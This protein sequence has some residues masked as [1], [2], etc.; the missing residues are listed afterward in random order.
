MCHVE[1]LIG[2][3]GGLCES[4]GADRTDIDRLSEEGAEAAALGAGSV[5][6]ERVL[7]N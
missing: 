2:V 6:A 3:E 1:R 5:E 4:F 7:M